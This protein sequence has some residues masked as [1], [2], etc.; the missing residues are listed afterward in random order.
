MRCMIL[1]L[2]IFHRPNSRGSLNCT[3]FGVIEYSTVH[4]CVLLQLSACH[5]QQVVARVLEMF[6]ATGS[7]LMLNGK[8]KSHNDLWYALLEAEKLFATKDPQVPICCIPIFA[9]RLNVLHCLLYMEHLLHVT[10]CS[11]CACSGELLS[12]CT[13]P[14]SKTVV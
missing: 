7:P 2:L 6:L 13:Q 14:Q 4:S 10:A 9:Y 11:L 12:L 8:L 3:I 1:L 5:L